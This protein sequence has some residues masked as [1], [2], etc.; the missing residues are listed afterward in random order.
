[1]AATSSAVNLP[2][3]GASSKAVTTQSAQAAGR[4]AQVPQSMSI[5]Y[6]LHLV[7]ETVGP[8][9]D[10]TVPRSG[11]PPAEHRR[12]GPLLPSDFRALPAATRPDSVYA[13]RGAVG[14]AANPHVVLAHGWHG[15]SRIAQLHKP[16]APEGASRAA[17]QGYSASPALGMISTVSVAPHQRHLTSSMSS[18]STSWSSMP[19]SPPR[20]KCQYSLARRERTTSNRVRFPQREQR[21]LVIR[22]GD[23][24][25]TPP[26]LV[27]RPQPARR[28]RAVKA[29]RP[30]ARRRAQPPT[31]GCG[32]ARICRTSLIA[33][34]ACPP[35]P[36]PTL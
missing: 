3:A 11:S 17:S 5:R 13:H 6:L 26:S 30:F 33:S 1:M 32:A 35:S 14:A 8:P 10:K 2:S 23:S 27:R 18:W 22:S 4:A 34:R 9:P 15:L 36:C 21:H 16:G 12:I 25:A 29:R 20:S 7:L 24:I 19:T 31:L 28:A